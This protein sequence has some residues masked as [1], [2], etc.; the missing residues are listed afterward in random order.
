MLGYVCGEDSTQS[1]AIEAGVAEW[2][3]DPKTG[4]KSFHFITS[5]KIESETK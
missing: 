3:I 4:K 5:S 1:K 2:R